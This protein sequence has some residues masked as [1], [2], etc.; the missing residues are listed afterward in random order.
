MVNN[1]AAAVMLVLA[2]L[3]QDR[4]VA[5]SRGE[6]VEIGGGFRIPDVME[7]SGARLVDV[8]TTN[9]TRLR[10]Y[11]KAIEHKRNDIALIMK[12]HP[13]NFAIEGF[14][15][16]TTVEQLATLSVPVVSDI[17]SGLLDNTAPWLQGHTPTI[18][19]WLANEPAAKQV[20][21]DGASLV[22]FSGDK[23][24][25]GPQCGIIAGR[26]DLVARCAAHPL[27]RALRPGSHTL[28]LLQQ[29]LLSYA[30]R[31]VC[32]DVPFWRMV[33]A[34]VSELRDRAENIVAATGVGSVVDLDSLVGAGSAPGST[35]ASVGI[36][37][38]G[39]ERANL[40]SHSVPVIART[41]GNTTYIDMRSIALTDDHVVVEAL[42]RLQ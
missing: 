40:R 29:V 27:M 36:A 35:I 6:S 42:S 15:E 2:A 5:V 34:S 24:L 12:I 8:G 37:I 10:D 11:A 28:L 4:D 16:S 18:P 1:N 17:G 9:R 26:A 7:Q 38:P 25:G 39:D 22:T 14:T 13:S 32:T 20:L 41:L 19:S 33:A 30:A 31:T 23:L 21:A 3:A